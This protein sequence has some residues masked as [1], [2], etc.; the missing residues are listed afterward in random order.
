ME[1][2]VRYFAV[3]K[4]ETGVSEETVTV[5]EGTTVEELVTMLIDLHPALEGLRKDTMVS[6]NRGVGS[7]DIVLEEG[8][9]VALFPPIQG[10]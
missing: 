3:H 6:V 4:D 10:G 8:D 2:R 9:D 5:P 1:I 7:G